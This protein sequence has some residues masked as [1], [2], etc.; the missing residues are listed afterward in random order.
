[1]GVEEK[2][3]Q[4]EEKME[5]AEEKMEQAEEKMEPTEENK[6]IGTSSENTPDN[7]GDNEIVIIEEPKSTVPTKILSEKEKKLVDEM[8]HMLKKYGCAFCS[9]RFDTKYAL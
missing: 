6:D 3:K 5:H 1:M 9:N 4:A 8:L 2:I 7:K